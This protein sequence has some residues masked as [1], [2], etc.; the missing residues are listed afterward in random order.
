MMWRW[1]LLRLRLSV[2]AND[3]FMRSVPGLDVK[4][5]VA[6]VLLG[7][8]DGGFGVSKLGYYAWLRRPARPHA[9]RSPS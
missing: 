3:A 1:L 7:C 2:A 6:A 5:R 8:H 9:G 4:Y